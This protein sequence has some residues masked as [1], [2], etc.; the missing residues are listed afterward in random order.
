MAKFLL[1]SVRSGITIYSRFF[2]PIARMEFPATEEAVDLPGAKFNP[3]KTFTQYVGRLQKATIL[4]N[5]GR[6]ADT[7]D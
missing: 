2:A 7:I 6:L 5:Q 3:G 4:L 1:P